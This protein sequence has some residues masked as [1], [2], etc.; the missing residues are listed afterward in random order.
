M[1]PVGKVSNA[2]ARP[3]PN[4]EDGLDAGSRTPP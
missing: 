4:G 3:P 1:I 2:I